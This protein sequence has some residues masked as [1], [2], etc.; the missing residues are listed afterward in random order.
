MKIR[1]YNMSVMDK[2]GYNLHID[3]DFSELTIPVRSNIK[4]EEVEVKEL[5]FN[6]SKEADYGLIIYYLDNIPFR[7]P[8]TGFYESFGIHSP[9]KPTALLLKNI[10]DSVFKRVTSRTN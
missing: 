8:V 4:N 10:G 5:S 9:K 3:E 2:N 7:D 1:L 6:A